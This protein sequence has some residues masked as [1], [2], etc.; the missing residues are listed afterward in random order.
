MHYR[1]RSQQQTHTVPP[2]SPVMPTSSPPEPIRLTEISQMCDF[3][4]TRK[5]SENN[6][7]LHREERPSQMTEP[8]AGVRQFASWKSPIFFAHGAQSRLGWCRMPSARKFVHPSPRSKITMLRMCTCPTQHFRLDAQTRDPAIPHQRGSVH[9]YQIRVGAGQETIECFVCKW[10][11]ML[12]ATLGDVRACGSSKNCFDANAVGHADDTGDRMC[13]QRHISRRLLEASCRDSGSPFAQ[14]PV[15]NGVEEMYNRSACQCVWERTEGSGTKT[16][17]RIH[18]TGVFS[19]P[20]FIH[21]AIQDRLLQE[22][23]V[24]LRLVT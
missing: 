4:K 19:T 11:K 24:R 6:S 22:G 21:R 15:K 17:L 7:V 8:Q 12:C 1:M 3:T 23:T 16:P 13:R 20:H 18:D 2:F 5:C 9:T 14:I 10:K